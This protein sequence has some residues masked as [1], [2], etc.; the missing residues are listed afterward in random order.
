M[1]S[2][3]ETGTTRRRLR[4]RGKSWETGTLRGCLALAVVGN[5]HHP[6]ATPGTWEELGNRHFARV[7]G[8]DGRLPKPGKLGNWR[9]LGN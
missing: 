8:P 9:K 2:P 7:F 1:L 3:P 6:G 4:G 5:G